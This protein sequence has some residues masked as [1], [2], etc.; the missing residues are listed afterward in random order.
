MAQ[1]PS[2]VKPGKGQIQPSTKVANPLPAQ[3][4]S[5]ARKGVRRK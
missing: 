5:V 1:T 4:T 2:E 3:K